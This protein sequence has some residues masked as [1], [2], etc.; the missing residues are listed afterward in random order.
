MAEPTIRA[1]RYF[2]A[3]VD[4]GSITA[5]AEQLHVVPSAVLAAVNQVEESFGLTLTTRQRSK[6]ITLTTTGQLVLP[7]VRELLD[8]YAALLTDA[9][10]MRTQLTGTVRIG[11]YA[12]VAPAF[13][14]SLAKHLRANG[15]NIEVEYIACDNRT[16]RLGLTTGQFDMI[17]CLDEGPTARVEYKPLLK[18]F[19][20]VLVSRCDP[21]AKR[22]SVSIDALEGRD[23]VLLDLPGVS[24]Y[25]R[26]ALET[27]GV[28]HRVVSTATSL[29][30][31]R[32]LVGAGIGCSLLHMRPKTDITYSGDRVAAIPIRPAVEPLTIVTGQ[33]LGNPR[34]A[35]QAF[36]DE[37]HRYFDGEGSS[38]LLVT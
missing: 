11:Y 3:A 14:P 28:D 2:V 18:V 5:A 25:Y 35:V 21:L 36:V 4:A 20:Y 37:L 7:Q 26:R 32:S 29:E 16:A 6:G 12:P 22:S 9:D 23:L 13:L 30:M 19:A 34:K 8:R 27:G 24:E 31:V 33:L 17:I 38:D 1:L 15:A 10:D